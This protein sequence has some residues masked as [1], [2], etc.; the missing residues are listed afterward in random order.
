MASEYETMNSQSSLQN[1]ELFDDNIHIDHHHHHNMSR[2]SVCTSSTS[3]DVDEEHDHD[4]FDDVDNAMSLYMSQLYIESF[5]ADVEFSD[6]NDEIT[7]KG[8]TLSSESENEVV[9]YYTSPLTPPTRR[10]MINH[11]GFGSNNEEAQK[12][13]VL[14]TKN[15]DP[16]RSKS[17][18]IRRDHK[19]WGIKNNPNSNNLESDEN[20]IGFRVITRPKGGKR[21]LCMDLEEVKACRDL[22]FELEHERMLDNFP[23]YVSFSNSTIDTSSGGNSPIPNWRISSPGDDPKD[24]K[25]RLKVWAQVVALVS[26]SKYGT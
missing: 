7:P 11:V 6:T 8:L 4:V 1:E 17:R 24:V 19:K 15:N 22:G 26:T 14:K 13:C 23:S 2:L 3:Y 25:A 5:D 10:N 21:C 9:S 12:G 18:R 16:L 20:G